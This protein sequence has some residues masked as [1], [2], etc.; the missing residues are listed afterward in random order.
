MPPNTTTAPLSVRQA[1]VL[2]AL[3]QG[4]RL[5][6]RYGDHGVET[7]LS[8][9]DAQTNSLDRRIVEGL[10]Q[11][12]ILHEHARRGTVVEFV[13]APARAQGEPDA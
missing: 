1:Q 9:P 5:S 10:L 13:E 11:K 6:Q 3:Q 8:W 4:A 2:R 7:Y 12:G